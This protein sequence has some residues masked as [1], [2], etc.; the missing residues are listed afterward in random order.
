MD[1]VTVISIFVLVFALLLPVLANG[2][3][4]HS[5]W[6]TVAKYVI[7]GVYIAANLYETILFR[8][9]QANYRAEWELLWSYRESLAFPDGWRSLFNGTVEVI[10]PLLLEEIILNILLYIPLGYLLPF[11]FEKLKPWQVVAIAF[12]CSALTEVTQLICKIGWFEFDDM[13]NNT[14]GCVI[15]LLI[16]RSVIWRRIRRI[17]DGAK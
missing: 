10:R 7:L 8:P 14:F 12:M 16:Y 2:L 17:P 6:F 11:M 13:L 1:Q 3:R 4:R 9:V 15:G 5:R